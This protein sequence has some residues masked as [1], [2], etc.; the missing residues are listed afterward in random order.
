LSPPPGGEK[1][2]NLSGGEAFITFL[3]QKRGK[4]SKRGRVI[5]T[6]IPLFGEKPVVKHP[7]FGCKMCPFGSHFSPVFA[8]N[9]HKNPASLN[10]PSASK[11][12][13]QIFL[14]VLE[15]YFF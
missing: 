8:E 13:F 5:K 12:N 9:T 3:G 10:Q 11:I 4:N 7:S 6:K 15:D 1:R 2:G 14:E